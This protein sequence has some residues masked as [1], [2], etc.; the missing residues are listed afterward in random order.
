VGP[1]A[2]SQLQAS[3]SAAAAK[4]AVAD[5]GASGK[6]HHEEAA[7]L[8]G[9]N[10]N[11]NKLAPLSD[12]SPSKRLRADMGETSLAERPTGLKSESNGAV[13]AV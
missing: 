1:H 2:V 5:F 3:A 11:N 9:N 13:L 6:H 10:N 12:Y 7:Y 4:L 8:S